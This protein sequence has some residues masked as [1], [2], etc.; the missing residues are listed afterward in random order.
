MYI[1][2]LVYILVDGVY[3]NVHVVYIIYGIM[4]IHVTQVVLCVQTSIY[5][6]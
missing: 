6:L 4:Y 3:I 5:T 1:L 2:W